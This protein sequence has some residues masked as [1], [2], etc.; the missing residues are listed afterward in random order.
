MRL[1]IDDL[2]K[3]NCDLYA[4]QT[5]YRASCWGGSLCVVPVVCWCVV[6]GVLNIPYMY[7]TTVVL[8]GD[9]QPQNHA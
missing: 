7:S 9:A 1:M 6:S 8:Q 2:S 3:G 5:P 4:A